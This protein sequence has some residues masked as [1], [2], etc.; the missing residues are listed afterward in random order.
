MCISLMVDINHMKFLEQL[1]LSC[2]DNI[3]SL[4]FPHCIVCVV[5]RKAKMGLGKHE[6]TSS[7]LWHRR[8]GYVSC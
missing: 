6:Y 4:L 7:L 8:G 2:K 1:T 3:L 5:Q